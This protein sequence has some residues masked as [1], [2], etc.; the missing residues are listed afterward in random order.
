MWKRN[1]MC[2]YSFFAHLFNKELCERITTAYSWSTNHS[3]NLTQSNPCNRGLESCWWLCNSSFRSRFLLV[4]RAGSLLSK[5][6]RIQWNTKLF[7]LQ[8]F[9]PCDSICQ[10]HDQTSV[11]PLVF[12]YV[13]FCRHLLYLHTI[14]SIK[15]PPCWETLSDA[16][17]SSVS[18][19]RQLRTPT[20]WPG[21]EQDTG[22]VMT[23]YVRE[24]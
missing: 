5:T 14:T 24:S 11:S 13:I 18:V 10:L 2:N 3:K 21:N 7:A 8:L 9:R 12:V 20:N 17:I 23:I 22:I 19:S 15:N 4:I 1:N 16:V 6:P